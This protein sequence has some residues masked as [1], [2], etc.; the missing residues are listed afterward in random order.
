MRAEFHAVERQQ[1]ETTC[2]ALARQAKHLNIDLLFIGSFGRKK[3]GPDKVHVGVLGT[4]ADGSLRTTDADICMVKSTSYAMEGSSTFLVPVDLSAKS[5]AR[6]LRPAAADS[7]HITTTCVAS[8]SAAQPT[9]EVCM[10]LPGA[11]AICTGARTVAHVRKVRAASC[12]LCVQDCAAPPGN[13][14]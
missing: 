2:E 6:R 11:V 12:R 9:S 10:Y 3:D 8:C 4:V 7:C 14:R 1:G 13:T 5:G